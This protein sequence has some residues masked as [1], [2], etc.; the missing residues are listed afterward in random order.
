MMTL[1]TELKASRAVGS[2]TVKAANAQEAKVVKDA[3]EQ[4]KFRVA[5]VYPMPAR[6]GAYGVV[7]RGLAGGR[8]KRVADK[9][10]KANG[11][12]WCKPDLGFATFGIVVDRAEISFQVTVVEDMETIIVQTQALGMLPDDTPSIENISW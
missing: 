6:D 12:A 2:K 7:L 9:I 3:L 10:V 1:L 8:M 5:K 11:Y 4:M